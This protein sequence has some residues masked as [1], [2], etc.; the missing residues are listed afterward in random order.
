[1][2]AAVIPKISGKCEVREVPTP[3]L[4]CRLLRLDRRHING[5]AVFYIGLEH[6]LISLIDLLDRDD[7][8]VGSDVMLAAKVEHFLRLGYTANLRAREAVTS[9]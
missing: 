4:P 6:S 3:E 7:L 5:E 9:K 1:M 8:Y 2:N